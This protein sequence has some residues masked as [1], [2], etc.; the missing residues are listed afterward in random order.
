MVYEKGFVLQGL[1]RGGGVVVVDG[2]P[3]EGS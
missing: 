1:R 2:L 3:C